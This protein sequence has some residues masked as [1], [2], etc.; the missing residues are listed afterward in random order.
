MGQVSGYLG[1]CGLPKKLSPGPGTKTYLWEPEEE[2]PEEAIPEE[3]V[4]LRG[5]DTRGDDTKGGDVRGEDIRGD[6]I[7]GGG[8]KGGGTVGGGIRGG[9]ILFEAN[10]LTSADFIGGGD[11]TAKPA[12][13]HF[14]YKIH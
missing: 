13:I 11:V 4:P 1:T 3:V 9:G 10:F 7:K 2:V 12:T 5:D 8:I 6:G 14:T